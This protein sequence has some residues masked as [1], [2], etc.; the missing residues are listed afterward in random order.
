[1]KKSLL[2]LFT[3]VLLSNAFSQ[4]N[5]TINVNIAG[6]LSSLLTANQK[7]TVKNLIVTG[8]IDAR[9]FKCMR[10][11]MPLLSVVD[12][13][14]AT[15]K[16]YSGTA[17]TYSYSTNFAENEIP[18]RSFCFESGYGKL[19]I[20]AVTLPPTITSIGKFAF[21]GTKN[22]A[23]IT[24]PSSVST[25]ATNAFLETP[26][27][28]NVEAGNP[29]FSS[30]DSVLFNKD[31]TLL[32][33]VPTS[34]TGSYSIPSTVLT[35]GESAFSRCE[36][37][38][39]VVFNNAL[40]TIE[41]YAFYDCYG[42]TSLNLPSKLETIKSSGFNFCKNL[43]SIS[44]P[45]S[46]KTIEESAFSLCTGNVTVDAGNQF[47]SSSD[48][49]LYNKDKTLLIHFPKNMNGSFVI[50][51][52]V[53]EI[54]FEAFYSC[55]DLT[56]ITFPS[57]LKHIR[58][59]AFMFCEKI[60]SANLPNGIIT[61]GYQSF[62]QCYALTSFIFPEGIEKISPNVLYYNTGLKSITLPSSI[63]FI[64]DQAF[65][66]CSRL[67]SLTVYKTSP[68]DMTDEWESGNAFRSIPKDKCTLYV[69][70]GS[71]SAYSKAFQ[72]EDFT[73]ITEMSGI[74]PSTLTLKFNHNSGLKKNYIASSA[75]WTA[76]SDKSWL[77]VNPLSK[78][79]SDSVSFTV[80]E[81]T[82]AMRSAKVTF[83]S[84][85]LTDK[86]VNV[87]QYGSAQY[88]AT[89]GGLKNI[90]G[91]RL[92]EISKLKL[93]GTIDAR[94]FKTMRDDMPFLSEVDLSNA[95]VVAY[96]GTEGTYGDEQYDYAANQIPTEAFADFH[97][98]YE[99]KIT[100]IIL[101]TSITSIGGSSFHNCG[102]LTSI[103]IPSSVLSIE[104]GVFYNCSKLRSIT[105]YS[106]KPINLGDYTYVFEGVNKLNCTLY[107]PYG[108]KALYQVANQWKEFTNIV[109][110][111]GIYPSETSLIFG[112][113]AETKVIS[114]A[115]SVAWTSQSDNS[116]LTI[117]PASGNAGV[118]Q[119][120]IIVT[121]NPSDGSRKANATFMAN[122][123]DNKFLEVTQFNAVNVVA[124]E[125]KNILGNQ[126]GNITSL[127]LIG[128][129]DARD[130][131]TMRDD[132]PLLTE[133]DL[134]DVNILSYKGEGGPS[135]Y[136]SPT[137]SYSANAIPTY[138]FSYVGADGSE[139]ILESVVFPVSITS[140]SSCVFLN[141][142]KLKSIIIPPL[143]KTISN[144]VFKNCESLNS[145]FIP[146][147]VISIGE[148]VF[149][150]SSCSITVDALNM[151]YCSTDGVLFNKNK[152][153]LLHAPTSLTGNYNVPASVTL[154]GD[155]AFN[156][157]KLITSL[158]LPDNLET[159]GFSS[160]T[161]CTG[162][163]SI[164]LPSAI[165]FI[166]HFVFQGCN[167]LT[168]LNVKSSL[169]VDLTKSFDI[170]GGINFQT[171]KLNVPYGTAADYRNAEQWKDFK[172][173]V[174][175]TS[176]FSIDANSM[177]IPATGE[178]VTVNVKANL[179][180]TASSEDNWI[181]ISP[182]SGSGNSSFK[183]KATANPGYTRIARVVVSSSQNNQI[184]DVVQNSGLPAMV[185]ATK[186][187]GTEP[188]ICDNITN[189]KTEDKY[190]YFMFKPAQSG[191][192]TFSTSSG[193]DT[194]GI[195]Y[196][197]NYVYLN[198]RDDFIF[199]NFEFSYYLN[200][201]KHYYFVLR[202]Y[203]GKSIEVLLNITGGDLLKMWPDK[204]QISLP[205]K[206][207]SDTISINAG[208]GS[209]WNLS[210][211]QP[212]LTINK[213]SGTGKGDII[214]SASA[215]DYDERKCNV[216]ISTQGS[217]A[218]IIT[219]TQESGN[220]NGF[221]L[222]AS[223]SFNPQINPTVVENSFQVTGVEGEL[224]ITVYNVNGKKVFASK[225]IANED[226]SA[227]E[228]KPGMYII[229]IENADNRA[230]IKLIKK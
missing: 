32:I 25:I 227:A 163:T 155:Y 78:S 36:K 137:T 221:D 86:V 188:V 93:S 134:S 127:K 209:T 22:L 217:P 198:Y 230:L 94:D 34:K 80:E 204:T 24:I 197:N 128:T 61:I 84:F 126:I 184:I 92:A 28:L 48:G 212:W 121:K 220:I 138:A 71:K 219:V 12:L 205:A 90:I 102:G 49:I 218:I 130:F 191:F 45:A 95:V 177:T 211:D 7:S 67:T 189:I 201:D 82:G 213:N 168:S 110:M 1:M 105:S 75:A 226:I 38:T 166:S 33:Q 83:S 41:K 115:S 44:I 164:T 140:I 57:G 117:N 179:Q 4:E 169:P 165:K 123:F 104:W 152:T 89:A 77:N 223:K 186:N 157:C 47:F 88:T 118:N 225:A 216:T 171:C 193:A 51:S 9:D 224:L 162:L 70:F 107:V 228:L 68:V 160:F 153:R 99:D 26:A 3:F 111:P 27:M 11:D 58:D 13:I 222:K 50:P 202:N 182:A 119:V 129:I 114:V 73:S 151:N 210:S 113:S 185:L 43:T 161:D 91:S 97:F 53:T 203:D 56:D 174:E 116:W 65:E 148:K 176:G 124:G 109:E 81:N 229:N 46:V 23:A 55:E 122:G 101:P 31:K 187:D 143:V 120:S 66:S 125:L 59:R 149:D 87:I 190:G 112:G 98:P 17:G 85:G 37:L 19:S 215:N 167:N 100:S 139:S 8:N 158:T 54:G 147:S 16:A 132:M 35:I 64:G 180:W 172:N 6:Q 173:I 214:L 141:C 196:D 135:P 142:G 69:P 200:Q 145:V 194:Y 10:D 206:A 5:L 29:N 156:N 181:T 60:Q 178:E 133:I 108:S 154:I 39:N 106:V 208:S 146:A 79:T 131:K 170:F 150:N 62:E 207:S 144:E 159:L 30:L 52:T 192:Y 96:S 15:I 21:R 2:L 20:T 40:L 136:S 74:F 183:I 72:W 42:L 199:D 103:D 18:E 14:G 195:L 63:T 76:V 175:A